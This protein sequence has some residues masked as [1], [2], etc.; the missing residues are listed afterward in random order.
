MSD[1]S[2]QPAEMETLLITNA[3]RPAFITKMAEL[4]LPIET[5]DELDSALSAVAQLRQL[6]AA[7]PAHNKFANFAQRVAGAVSGGQAPSP[8]D[9]AVI[10][11][12]NDPTVA[13]AVLSHIHAT[14]QRE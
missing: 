10:N 3:Y 5:E 6:Q 8:Y 2:Q 12:A 14:L 11:L 7:A 13:A 1:T 9:A 4:G